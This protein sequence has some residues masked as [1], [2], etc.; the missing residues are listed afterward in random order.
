MI[1]DTVIL[2]SPFAVYIIILKKPTAIIN[3]LPGN[4]IRNI[5]A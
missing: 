3:L 5:T 2:V 1:T 4:K